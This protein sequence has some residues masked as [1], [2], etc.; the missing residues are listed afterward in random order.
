M[1]ALRLAAPGG[2][3]I[4]D[5]VPDPAPGPGEVVVAVAA[6]GVCHSDV[7]YHDGDPAPRSMPVTLGHE[8]AG[9]VESVGSGVD[10]GLVGTPVAVHY[11][12]ACGHCTPC[13][14]DAEMFCSEYGMFG[15]THDGGWAERIA[16]PRRSVVP[17]PEAVPPEHAAVMMCSSATSL[18]AL[19]R[20]G[21]S[22]GDRVAV[23]GVGGLGL[24]AVQIA[25]SLGAGMVFAID[26]SPD[27]LALAEAL[28][29]VPLPAGEQPE[30]SLTAAGGVHVALDLV[31]SGD[32]L[33]A[34][35]RSVVPRGRVVAVGISARSLPIDPYR[36]LIGPEASI[37][38]SN[39]H[40][41]A[42]SEE[43]LAMA[44]MGALR[45]D[46]IVTERVP[47]DADAV[48]AVLDRMRSH[49]GGVRTVITP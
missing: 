1:R 27:R 39:D 9:T 29:A 35:L 48:S 19:R 34:A 43:V 10:P 11:L 36:D 22:P 18:H 28:G 17:V 49:G 6:A 42:E 3:L 13:T 5:D 32:V 45:L 37:L 2:P 7:H 16:V 31:G 38:G 24:S 40:T 47:L 14:D 30:R 20:A 33:A 12:L 8:T 15:H 26:R 23:F 41:L 46:S 4:L 25:A 21:L 44:E